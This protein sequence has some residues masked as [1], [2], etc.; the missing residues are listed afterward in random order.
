MMIQVRGPFN[1]S[2]GGIPNSGRDLDL[3][4]VAIFI[5]SAK[6]ANKSQIV[7]FTPGEIAAAG[8]GAYLTNATL[9]GVFAQEIEG[10]VIMVERE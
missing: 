2:S 7:F 4:Q 1:R 10:A 3:R 9:N 8:Y 6:V 5:K